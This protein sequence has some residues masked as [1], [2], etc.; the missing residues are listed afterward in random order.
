[1]SFNQHPPH[2]DAKNIHR[3]GEWIEPPDVLPDQV[4]KDHPEEARKA[5]EE[6]TADFRELEA[7]RDRWKVSASKLN[8]LYQKGRIRGEHD[9][10]KKLAETQEALAVADRVKELEEWVAEIGTDLERAVQT[11]DWRVV[12]SLRACVSTWKPAW[13]NAPI[14]EGDYGGDD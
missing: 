1:M 8:E 11:R 2:S 12:E 4:K 13:G 5:L 14:T 10:A 3:E 6:W 9:R 7:D